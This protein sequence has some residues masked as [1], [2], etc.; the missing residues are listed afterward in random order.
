MR[1]EGKEILKNESKVEGKQKK[2][3]EGEEAEKKEAG[4]YRLR[5]Y[6]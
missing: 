4:I 3:K 1:M 6:T 5:R 2:S